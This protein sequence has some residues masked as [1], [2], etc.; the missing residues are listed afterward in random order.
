MLNITVFVMYV[1]GVEYYD[2]L[3]LAVFYVITFMMDTFLFF[4][5]YKIS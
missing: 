3:L 1:N 4:F 5:F 2:T